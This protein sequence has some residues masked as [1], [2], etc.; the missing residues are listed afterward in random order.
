[1]KLIE[2]ETWELPEFEKNEF[3]P[4]KHKY[5]VCI[6]VINEGD[7]FHQQLEKMKYLSEQIDI[8]IADGGSNDGSTD[9]E[10]LK[11]FNINTLLVKKSTGKVGTQMRMAFAWA[12]KRG[13]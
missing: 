1:M 9:H 11:K 13:Y 10:K 5:C 3:V 2:E 7:K 6:F 4:K 8:V 12:L